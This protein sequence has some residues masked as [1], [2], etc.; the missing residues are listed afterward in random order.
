MSDF[1]VTPEQ[2]NAWNAETLAAS[3]D[4]SWRTLIDAAAIMIVRI[5]VS[6]E[7]DPNYV[8]H[9][10]TAHLFPAAFGQPQ[11]EFSKH[12]IG[13][14]H[15]KSH[16]PTVKAV[17]DSWWTIIIREYQQREHQMAAGTMLGLEMVAA[18]TRDR[19]QGKAICDLLSMT[20]TEFANTQMTYDRRT[21]ADAAHDMSTEALSSYVSH[22]QTDL[23]APAFA[24]VSVLTRCVGLQGGADIG[25]AS[26]T[27]SAIDRR[28]KRYA[29]EG[30]YGC[31]KEQVE[32]DEVNAVLDK[33]R[34]QVEAAP[35][36]DHATIL[37]SL[38]ID[39]LAR[40]IPRL[41]LAERDVLIQQV[42][43]YITT[44]PAALETV[45]VAP[46]ENDNVQA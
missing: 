46:S 7:E 4:A 8:N 28:C 43:A 3:P 33:W 44:G 35:L 36:L 39:V 17:L 25:K 9:V 13:D 26:Q 40:I 24:A 19:F 6:G 21:L 34:I 45:P 18:L 29:E 31:I 27:L 22:P 15:T 30:L 5:A 10:V 38:A 32:G 11:P 42:A 1:Q 41:V 23:T 2:L 37:S 12:R 20:I 16:A 14:L